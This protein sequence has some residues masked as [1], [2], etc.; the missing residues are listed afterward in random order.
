MNPMLL[1]AYANRPLEILC[2]GAHA[3]DIEIGAGGTLLELL[4]QG[5]EAQVHWVVFSASE[6]RAAEARSSAEAF[7]AKAQSSTVTVLGFRESYFPYV[8]G[9][10]KDSFA[11][12]CRDLS[13]DLVFT[14]SREDRHQD[15]RVIS[16]L[17][18]NSFRDHMILEYEIPKYDG[19]LGTPNI[20]FPLSETVARS[21]M[22]LL[23]RH[24][25][26]QRTRHWFDRETFLGL[27]RLRGVESCCRYA[28]A[29]QCR[30][31]TLGVGCVAEVSPLPD[32][33]ESASG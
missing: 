26:S 20:F 29:F 32:T 22:D 8:G 4:D 6:R 14:H 16:D 25:P 19:D 13:P 12:L 10:I 31:V 28:E 33:V 2:L 7:L 5:L 17:T 15:H 23:E 30:K 27:M 1:A 3:D 9:E 18:W 21:K 11:D 24:F